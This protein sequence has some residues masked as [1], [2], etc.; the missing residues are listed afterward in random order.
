[1]V[2]PPEAGGSPQVR[3][4]QP[5]DAGEAGSTTCLKVESDDVP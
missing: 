4:V 3:V 5:F 1:M 2:Q